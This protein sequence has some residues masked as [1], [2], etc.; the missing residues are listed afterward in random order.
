[1][2]WKPDYATAAELKAYLRIGDTVDDDEI[3]FALTTASR[4][5]DQ[6]TNRQFGQ[7]TTAVARRYTWDCRDRIDG[8]R[9]LA[10]DDIPTT[11][12]LAVALDTT[13]DGV[14]DTTLTIG[15]DFE[16][17]PFNVALDGWPWTHLLLTTGAS[18]GFPQGAGR[19]QVTAEFGWAAVPTA[20]KQA[21][22]FQAS[23]FFAV[24]NAPFGVAGSP[25]IGS[26]LRLLD[27]VHPDVEV[28][29]RPYRRIW[30]AA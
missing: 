13:G 23:R 19:V 25:E 29:L 14:F 27:R 10:V 18:T 28:A 30:A 3:D 7:E 20:I 5:V 8:R 22:L 17:W 4:D 16:L 15:D 11:D 9:A 6:L 26:E 24:R 21:T 12:N 1:M 2:V